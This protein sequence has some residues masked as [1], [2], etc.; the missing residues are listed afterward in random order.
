MNHK[1]SSEIIFFFLG[2]IFII[3]GL[4]FSS[5]TLG[6]PQ[7]A[8]FKNYPLFISGVLFAVG[9][10]FVVSAFKKKDGGNDNDKEI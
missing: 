7:I 3:L 6:L 2:I 9:L 10:V 5:N 1:K 8:F 4:V